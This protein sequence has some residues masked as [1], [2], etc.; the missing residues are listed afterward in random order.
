MLNQASQVLGGKAE[1]LSSM[2]DALNNSCYAARNAFGRASVAQALNEFFEAWFSAFDAQAETMGSLADATQQCAVIYD[3]VDRQAT[4][5]IAA[6]QTAPPPP[7]PSR[8]PDDPF[9]GL[10]PHPNPPMA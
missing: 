10:F 6:M 7:P 9:G 5:Y 4:G 3:H 2:R 8:Q 1:A